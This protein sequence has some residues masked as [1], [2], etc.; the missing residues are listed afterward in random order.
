M[1]KEEDQTIKYLIDLMKKQAAELEAKNCQL[2]ATNAQLAE[3][4]A[5]LAGVKSE[6]ATRILLTPKGKLN[7]F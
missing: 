5:E 6:L 4:K 1:S 2:E 7:F 3:I